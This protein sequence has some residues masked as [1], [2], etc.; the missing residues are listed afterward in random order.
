[1]SDIEKKHLRTVKSFVK[2]AGRMTQRQTNALEKHADSYLIPY[3]P[4]KLALER[5]FETTQNIVLEIGF[6]MGTS[7]IEMAKNNPH[8]NYL[9]LEVHEPG[10]GN[11]LDLIHQEKLTNLKVV[12]HDAVEVL[13]YNIAPQSLQGIQIFFPDPWHKKRHHKRR[14][15]NPEFITIMSNAL[16]KGGFIHFASDWQPYAEEVLALF[17]NAPELI[18]QFTNFAPRPETRPLTK[19]EKRGQ[20]LEHPIKD[21]IFTKID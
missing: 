15:V 8:I 6:G 9:G 3:Q 20:N 11:I 2:R 19:F 10:V 17:T 16:A 1:M 7:L 18:N 21:I 13:K 12:M 14:L 5:I 4:Q